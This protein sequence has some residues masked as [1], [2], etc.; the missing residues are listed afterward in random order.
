M[1][2]SPKLSSG[3]A[4][5]LLL[6]SAPV[7]RAEPPS[8]PLPSVTVNGSS[9]PIS[10]PRGSRLSV[11][12]ENGPGNPGEWL[13]LY[14]AEPADAHYITWQYLDG[15]QGDA[16]PAGR[17]SATILFDLPYVPGDYEVRLL[18]YTGSGRIAVA[19][20]VTVSERDLAITLN[21]A[22]S[23][24][25]V[26]PG[27]RVNVSVT[28]PGNAKDWI[29]LHPING[30]DQQHPV[31]LYLNGSTEP[32]ATGVRQ[33]TVSFQVPTEPGIYN[34]RFFLN[35]KYTRIAHSAPVFVTAPD[36][37]G[38]IN[39]SDQPDG[40]PDLIG[41]KRLFASLRWKTDLGTGDPVDGLRDAG[42]DDVQV[43]IVRNALESYSQGVAVAT[44]MVALQSEL[45]SDGWS[46]LQAYTQSQVK[47]TIK[48]IPGE[49]R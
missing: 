47:T 31:W 44:L 37:A 49:N 16:A 22:T 18:P 46:K 20:R 40:I 2:H 21:G 7:L 10:V 25:E 27:A 41:Y 36:P 12:L 48:I 3:A 17:T 45:G 4:L 8:N 23:E 34:F 24:I 35:D 14:P 30:N 29:G 43:G 39:G 1:R 32:P 38:T 19:P 9:A 6:L 13:A 11:R 5:A 42:L 26:K 15:T 28:G 33:A